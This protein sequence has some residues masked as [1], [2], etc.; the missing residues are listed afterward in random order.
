MKRKIKRSY[1]SGARRAQAAETRLRILQAARKLFSRHG[2]DGVTIERLAK[3]ARVATPTVYALFKS[4]AGL[5]TAMMQG[6]LFGGSYGELAEKADRATDPVE[7]M[8]I[9]ASI[10]RSIYDNEKAE[11]GLIRGAAAFSPELKKIE[12][13]FEQLRFGL[14]EKRLRSVAESKAARHG[15]A[16]AKSRDIMWA[17]TGRD[18]Y[19]MLVVERGWTSDEYERWLCDTL[20]ATL[21][22]RPNEPLTRSE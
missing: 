21:I 20:V 15:L 9:T 11:L 4:K 1:D 5:L 2:I 16:L 22:E 8:R 7:V 12:A 17:L 19:R 13:R 18:V 14:Q 3:Q 10:A 6:S